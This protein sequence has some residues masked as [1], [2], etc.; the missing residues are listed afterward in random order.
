MPPQS[1]P[2]PRRIG[3]RLPARILGATGLVTMGLV[4]GVVFSQVTGEDCDCNG[5]IIAEN[6]ATSRGDVAAVPSANPESPLRGASSTPSPTRTPRPSATPSNTPTHTLTRTPAPTD[7]G[8]LTGIAVGVMEDPTAVRHTASSENT[9]DFY[10]MI[11]D[12]ALNNNPDAVV[13][14]TSQSGRNDTP[15]G[16]WSTGTQWAI[17]TV[18]FTALPTSTTFTLLVTVASDNAFVV[19][20]NI[21]NTKANFLYLDHPLLNNN[22]RATIWITPLMSEVA[23]PYPTRLNYGGDDHWYILNPDGSDMKPGVKFHVYIAP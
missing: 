1:M 4:G 5:S 11:D 9:I 21:A 3:N 20:A 8:G 12:P 17:Y 14:I 13:V 10:T 15:V 19:E 18:D 22:P 23:N 2:R 7:T 16:V 6:T